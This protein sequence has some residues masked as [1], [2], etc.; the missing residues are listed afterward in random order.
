MDTNLYNQ[1]FTEYSKSVFNIENNLKFWESFLS[2]S[3]EKY[4]DENNTVFNRELFT[5][6]F[7][8]Y[9]RP[10]EIDKTWIYES[11]LSHKIDIFDLKLSNHNFFDWVM[12][13]S[14]IDVYN[15][16]ELLLFQVIGIRYFPTFKNPS[17]GKD[18]KNKL[19]K[20]IVSHLESNKIKCN[21]KNNQFLLDL[22]KFEC[23]NYSRFLELKLNNEC[24]DNW[25]DF[26]SFFSTLRNIITHQGVITL[27]HISLLKSKSKYLY[28]TY[29]EL[30]DNEG[31]QILKPKEGLFFN[32]LTLVNDFSANTTKYIADEIDLEFIGFIRV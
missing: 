15:N 2:T 5:S 21:K 12:C 3:V 31:N 27:K 23:P 28:N 13:L 16:V 22:M 25:E 18:E 29:F 14:L 17:L 30:S 24:E 7:T 19:I 32:F 1:Y 4:V 8:I 9:N 26:Y 20:K 10:L 6:I 11:Q